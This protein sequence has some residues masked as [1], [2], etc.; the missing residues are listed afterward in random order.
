MRGVLISMTVLIFCM[1]MTLV[2]TVDNEYFTTENRSIYGWQGQPYIQTT[3]LKSVNSSTE[4]NETV[5][6]LT[7]PSQTFLDQASDIITGTYALGVTFIS[8]LVN[9]IINSTV[10]FGAFLQTMGG[11]DVEIIS[12][13]VATIVTVLVNMNHAMLL[14]QF[15]WKYSLKDGA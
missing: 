11:N 15:I 13:E 7:S 10:G 1:S 3:D 14:G 12:D 4:M 8:F 6:D 5:Y 9:T 2:N